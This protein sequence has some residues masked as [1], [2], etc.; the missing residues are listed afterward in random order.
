MRISDWSSDVCSSDLGTRTAKYAR[1]GC[2]RAGSGLDQRQAVALAAC[3]LSRPGQRLSWLSVQVEES[4]RAEC[5]RK[6]GYDDQSRFCQSGRTAALIDRK[7]T[8][9]NSSH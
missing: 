8:R 3:R 4:I 9:L 7:S 1:L 2:Q 6:P 5:R